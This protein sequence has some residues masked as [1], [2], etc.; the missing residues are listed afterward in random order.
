MSR[1]KEHIDYRKFITHHF[2]FSEINDAF[3][4]AIKHKDQAIKV[5]LT[6]ES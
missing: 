1:V 3:E 2:D 5:M 6:M 4:T